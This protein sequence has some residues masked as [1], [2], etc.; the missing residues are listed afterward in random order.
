M[1]QVLG[2]LRSSPLLLLLLVICFVF[3]KMRETVGKEGGG[4]AGNKRKGKLGRR[5]NTC[6]SK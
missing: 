1:F 5:R 6:Y 3:P 2:F 4:K